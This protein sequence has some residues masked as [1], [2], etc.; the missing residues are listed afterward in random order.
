MSDRPTRDLTPAEVIKLQEALDPVR[1]ADPSRYAVPVE[2]Q[3][4]EI[5]KAPDVTDPMKITVMNNRPLHITYI[6][7]ERKILT[8]L[9]A[10]LVGDDG[11]GHELTPDGEGCQVCEAIDRAESRLREVDTPPDSA[12]EHINLGGGDDWPESTMTVEPGTLTEKV[13]PDE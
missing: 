12:N 3:S 6:P 1:A 8:D 13:W 4:F 11:D 10:E 7:P 2:G 5:L 9:I